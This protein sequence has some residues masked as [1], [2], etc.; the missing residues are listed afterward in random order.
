MEKLRRDG[1]IWVLLS[2]G[3]SALWGT[4]FA[5]SENA[6]IDF[7]AVYAGT[8]CLIHRHNPY[9]ASDLAREYLSED[10]QRPLASPLHFQSITLYV[11][12]PTAFAVV[13]PFAV[14]SWEPAH[15]LWM[16]LTGG[17]FVLAM[18]LMWSAGASR[19]PLVSTLLTCLI[20]INCEA[21]FSSGN[22]AGFVVGLCGIA[23]W[24]FLENRLSWIGVI[25][26]G[27]SLAVK[28]HDS[29]FVWLYFLLVGGV[30]RKR[31][32]QSLLIASAIG[33]ISILWIWHVAPD[34]MHD[35][36]ANMATISA[37]GGINEPGPNAVHDGTLYSI[38]DLEGAISIFRDEPHFYNAVS[39][40]LC[41]ALLLVWIVRTLRSPF[42]LPKAWL[43]L[44][45]VVPF[46][47]LINY[48]RLWDAKLVMLAIP[49]CCLLWSEGS[50]IGKAAIWITSLAVLMTGEI[51][52]V[53][54]EMV[55]GS[56]HNTN[57]ILARV[58]TVLLT[59]PASISLLAMGIFYLWVYARR[60]HWLQPA[61]AD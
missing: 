57:G 10:G 40:L 32:L 37:R 36:N 52:L 5:V 55:F 44:A 6:W 14:F 23:V 24:C 60:A 39:Y 8:R 42:T 49:A 29:G 33:L 9:S 21:F 30:Y 34:W 27:L 16:L 56:F 38:V 53:L 51:S 35:W 54:F 13:A 2:I 46:T 19:A 17:A 31:A 1:L 58:A 47:L 50:S 26:L 45:A 43:A 61:Q 18:L 3:I 20:A 48:H 28:P 15:I 11:N 25:C 59:R 41:G 12:M 22:T 4:S 7:R